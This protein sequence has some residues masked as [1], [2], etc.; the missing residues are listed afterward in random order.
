[1]KNLLETSGCEGIQYY[2]GYNPDIKM[3]PLRYE[4]VMEAVDKDRQSLNVYME[5]GQ[6]C[7]TICD[8]SGTGDCPTSAIPFGWPFTGSYEG[9]EEVPQGTLYEMFHYVSPTLFEA[10]QDKEIFQQQFSECF[11]LFKAGNIP[12]ARQELRKQLENMMET[13]LETY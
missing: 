1:L 7:P 10:I 5:V 13:Y 2:F 9:Y 4:A 3:V 8:P 6:L 11:S 12:E